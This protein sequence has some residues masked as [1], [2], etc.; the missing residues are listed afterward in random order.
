[1]RRISSGQGR[2]KIFCQTRTI[3]EQASVAGQTGSARESSEAAERRGARCVLTGRK[4]WDGHDFSRWDGQPGC[5]PG[6]LGPIM[7]RVFYIC[8]MEHTACDCSPGGS[9]Q[10]DW[11][12]SLTVGTT[13]IGENHSRG[14]MQN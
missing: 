3:Q 9:A 6:W 10:R 4:D 1:M 12:S 8:Y 2:Q 13:W 7:L 11:H 5:S 14:G